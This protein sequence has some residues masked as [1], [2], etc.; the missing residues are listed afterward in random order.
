MTMRY[1]APYAARLIAEL[2]DG[3]VIKLIQGMET[4]GRCARCSCGA[5]HDRATSMIQRGYTIDRGRSGWAGLDTAHQ[6][7]L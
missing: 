5:R 7:L 3:T 1:L 4:T 6:W 2:P